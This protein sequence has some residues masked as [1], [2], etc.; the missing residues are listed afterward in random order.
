MVIIG[1]IVL[2]QDL[3]VEELYMG[4]FIRKFGCPSLLFSFS[5]GRKKITPPLT[6]VVFFFKGFSQTLFPYHFSSYFTPYS[7]EFIDFNIQ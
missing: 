2:D 3:S 1:T 7:P 4:I 5:A 6:P